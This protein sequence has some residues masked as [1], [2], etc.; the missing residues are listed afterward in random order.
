MT[1]VRRFRQGMAAVLPALALAIVAAH[2]PVARAQTVEQFYTGRTITLIVPFSTG[3]YYDTGARLIARHMG[4]HMPGKPNIVVQNQPSAGGIGL[5]NRFAHASE[6]DGTL[7]GVLQRAIPQVAL[8]GDPNAKY[9]PV[10]LT[11][12]GSLSGYTTDSYLMFVNAGHKVQKVDDLRSGGMKAIMGA[13]R[14]GSTNLMLALVARDVLKLNIDIVRGF[15]GANDITLA[16]S[17]GEVDGQLADLSVLKAGMGGGAWAA[18]KLRP[19]VQFARTSRLVE[20]PAVP[21]ARE[22]VAS[23]EDKAVLAFAE[24]PFFMALPLAGPAGMPADRATAIG[25]AFMSLAKDDGFMADAKKIGY[26]GDLVDGDRVRALIAEAAR[27]PQDV[28]A[29]YK[30]IISQ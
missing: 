7:I 18:G 14:S 22:L 16:Q 30:K 8:M 20:L 15:P 28:I 23:A 25:T 9:D 5:A 26:P 29:R 4:R 13:N 2:A 24:L 1:E 11:W 12:F 6:K 27:T 10:K 17:R 19:L 21:I 3:G